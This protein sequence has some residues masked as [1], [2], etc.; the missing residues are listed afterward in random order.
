[1]IHG[2]LVEQDHPHHRHGRAEGGYPLAGG[3]TCCEADSGERE[4]GDDNE[5][6]PSETSEIETG[7]LANEKEHTHHY[8]QDAEPDEDP[9]QTLV[10][11][12][13]VHAFSPLVVFSFP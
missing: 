11:T 8:Q 2:I 13:V 5:E 1:V 9:A 3:T 12:L 10:A 6:R 7:G 4:S